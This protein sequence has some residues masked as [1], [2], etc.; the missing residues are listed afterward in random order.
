M[1]KRLV[2]KLWKASLHGSEGRGG[3]GRKQPG[4]CSP[5]P[6]GWNTSSQTLFLRFVLYSPIHEKRSR[7]LLKNMFTTICISTNVLVNYWP[8][9]IGYLTLSILINNVRKKKNRECC[10]LSCQKWVTSTESWSK[11]PQNLTK[12][13]SSWADGTYLGISRLLRPRPWEYARKQRIV[14]LHPLIA[15]ACRLGAK[16]DLC[17]RT[18]FILRGRRMSPRT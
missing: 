14:T 18:V 5:D 16:D 8:A 4:P 10:E 13:L 7:S 6:R 15:A 9:N 12:R 3:K 17:L 2:G 1:K 11:Q